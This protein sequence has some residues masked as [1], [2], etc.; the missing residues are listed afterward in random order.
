MATTASLTLRRWAIAAISLLASIQSFAQYTS[1][2]DIYGGTPSAGTAPNVLIILDNTGN[3]SSPFPSEKDA[4]ITAFNSLDL[5]RFRVG[6]MLF[7]ETGGNDSGEGGGY[8]RAALRL[9]DADYKTKLNNLLTSLDVNADKGN[10]GKAGLAMAE[11]YAY[12]SGGTPFAGNNKGKTDY[13][14]NG[15]GS[16]AS[17]AV[18]ALPGNALASKAATTYL[19]PAGAVCARNYIIYIS[20][21]AAQDSNSDND[22]ASQLLSAAYAAVGMTRPAE[23]S[24]TPNGSQS[25]KADEWARFMNASPTSVTTFTL[26]VNKV[27]TGQG[28]GWTALLK[29]MAAEGGGQY[30]DVNTA[31]G[32]GQVLSA[33]NNV[34]N[35]IQ[36]VNSVFSSASLPVSVNARG[37]YLNQVFMGMFR[38]DGDANP[39]WRGNLKQY[40]F[41]YDVATDSLYLAG[42]NGKPAI[43]GSTGF[44]AP[45][46]V[47]YWTQ[48]STFWSQQM[49]GTPPSASDSPDGEV[50]EKGGIAQMIRSAYAT[51][52]ADRKVYTCVGCSAGTNLATAATAAFSTANSSNLTAVASDATER[53][54]IINWVRGTD[55]AGDESGPGGTTTIR[56]SVHGDV[57]HSRPAVVNYGTEAAPKV[58]VFYGSNDGYLRAINGNQTGDNAGTELWGFIPQEHFGKF[59][60]LR[61]NSPE[62]RLSTTSVLATATNPPILRDYFV[63]GPISVYQKVGTNGVTTKAYLYFAMRRGGRFLYAL[64]VTDPAQPKFLWK[65]SSSDSG[66]SILGQTWSEPRITKLKGYTSTAP[67]GSDDPVIVM[68]AGYDA[69]AEDAATPGNTTM[70]NAVLVL[71]ARTG[72]KIAQ[73]NTER[74]VAADVTLVDSDYDGYVDRAYAVDLG[75]NIYRIDFETVNSTAQS[76]WGMYKLA[77]LKGTGVRKF[78][79]A[80][81]V[82]PTKTFTAVQVGSGDREKP[83]LKTTSDAFFTVFDDTLGKGTVADFTAFTPSDLGL[84]GSTAN[85]THGC[86]IN[87]DSAGEKVVNGAV[88]FRGLTY[89]GTN[90]P[91]PPATNSCSA[92]L[93]EAKTY[94]VPLFCRAPSSSVLNGGGLPPSPVAGFVTVTYE[95]TNADGTTTTVTKQKDF[96]IGAPNSKKSGIETGKTNATLNVPRKRRYWYQENAR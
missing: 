82:V 19:P 6:L 20:N 70:G 54:A 49:L 16:A 41:N 58:V 93:G 62:V 65:K 36:A 11:A 5:N 90:K 46:A 33:L 12:L 57:L 18:Y 95:Q 66:F 85:M 88:S 2:I 27:T 7:T 32:P 44:V 45:D 22:K 51:S 38:P 76:S 35:Q 86:Y 87:M 55:N 73:F 91:T 67:D 92:N 25:N 39:R 68:G 74:S 30:F 60:R 21:N 8:V 83:L 72:E 79:Y 42:A 43:S 94:S 89:F 56:P 31:G 96:V 52:Q 40:K 53:N 24:I 34:F 9:L 80:P 71:N 1:D 84:V 75:G 81:D 61:D 69:A 17:N 59:K 37:T 77:A 48:P 63:D 26:D 47:S 29:S 15:G 23:I 13:T 4:L 28:P 50:V 78:F 14:G 64:D 10:S 3:W